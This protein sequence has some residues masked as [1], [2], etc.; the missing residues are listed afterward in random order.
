MPIV[1]IADDGSRTKEA[2]VSVERMPLSL[3]NV[4]KELPALKKE[5]G[6]RWKIKN[7]TIEA[8]IPRMKNPLDPKQVLELAC[9][10][11]VVHYVI[12]PALKAGVADPVGAEL[13][14][15]VTRWLK[16]FHKSK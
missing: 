15:Y 6:K 5:L 8:R 1:R 2:F 9:V 4:R 13:K 10:G 7:V 14:R 11:I 3:A 16:R 12:G